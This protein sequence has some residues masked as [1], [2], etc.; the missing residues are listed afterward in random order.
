MNDR[1]TFSKPSPCAL[2]GVLTREQVMD[3][4]IRPRPLWQGMPWIAG[5]AYTVRCVT[6]DKLMLHAAIYRATPGSV[7]VMEAGDVDHA[8]AGG[9]V[10]A[11][12]QKRGVAAFVIDGVSRNLAEIRELRFPV[13][14]R[15]VIPIPGGK[16]TLGVLGGPV[17]CGGVHVEAG[18][19]VV[20]DEE[21]VVVV[22]SSQSD[23]VLSRVQAREAKDADET[24]ETWEAAHR[25]RTESILR[26]KGFKEGAE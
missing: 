11:V 15:G 1:A 7:I 9:N 4:G 21:G 22:P 2:A 26:S 24:L 19:I 20:A 12:A 10:C 13:F 3:I 18:D 25:V 14:A 5:P 16:E 6:G 17:R 23:G 8:V